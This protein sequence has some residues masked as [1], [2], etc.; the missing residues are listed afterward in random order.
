MSDCNQWQLLDSYFR[1]DHKEWCMFNLLV[2]TRKNRII[3]KKEINLIFFTNRLQ[4]NQGHKKYQEITMKFKRKNKLIIWY[5]KRA[6]VC[7]DKTTTWYNFI[8]L[9][10]GRMFPRLLVF[11]N[12]HFCV[13]KNNSLIQVFFLFPFDKA[14]V[15]F[16]GL[17]FD[18][19][20]NLNAGFTLVRE[21]LYQ[22]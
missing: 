21:Y 18:F 10:N 12:F 2:S 15:I 22:D 20:A 11:D 16:E 9:I 6:Y 3:F 5:F 14:V 19:I 13:K 4:D 7:Q 17:V 1:K 8:M